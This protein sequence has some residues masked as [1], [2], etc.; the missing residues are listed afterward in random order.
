MSSLEAIKN[1][2]LLSSL[3]DQEKEKL[4]MFCQERSLKEWDILFEDWDDANAMY[5]LVIW[6]IEIF[7]NLSWEEKILWEIKAEEFLWE[8][9]IFGWW[10]KRMATARAVED[11]VLI[12]MLSFS[13]K[14][15]A[16]KHPDI[17]AKIE[18]I[19]SLR[20]IENK[21]IK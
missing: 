19:I 9:A 10:W 4:S 1:F 14:E 18:E 12:T 13:I 2:N 5:F 15:L 3:S 16:S 8:M 7:K 21:K 11:S 17:M 20:E 6:K